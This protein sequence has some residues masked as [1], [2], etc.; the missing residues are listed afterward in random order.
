MNLKGNKA[1]QIDG[2]EHLSRALTKSRI[3]KIELDETNRSCNVSV[4]F[5]HKLSKN[6]RDMLR[7]FHIRLVT[8]FYK[9]VAVFQIKRFCF[10]IAGSPKL[11]RTCAKNKRYLHYK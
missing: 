7:C 11:F 3:I 10:L 6:L 9:T 2:L 4:I 8:N 1:I 5:Y